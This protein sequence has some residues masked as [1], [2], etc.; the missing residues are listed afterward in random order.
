M[1]D[2]LVIVNF[3]RDADRAMPTALMNLQWRTCLR[4]ITFLHHTEL[5]LL[6][7]LPQQATVY[8]G[9]QAYQFLLEVICGLHSPLFG[10]TAVMGQFRM[11][12]A[13]AEFA[14]SA[15][16][17]FLRQLT[18]NLLVDA[19]RIRHQYLEGLGSQS[20]GSLVRKHLQSSKRIALLG[21]GSLAKEILP[22]LI[23]DAEVRL[24]YRSYSHAQRLSQEYK[25]QLDQFTMADAG[26]NGDAG[27]LVVAA[28]L[29]SDEITR[30]LELQSTRF[31]LIVDLRSNAATDPINVSQSLVR[32]SELFASLSYERKRMDQRKR[33]A[34]RD[35]ELIAGERYPATHQLCA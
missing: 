35:I 2:E 32:L 31:S 5:S 9:Q 13:S 8:R 14:S 21:T 10:E 27:A 19:R 22:W 30:W 28:P 20:Y 6:N 18:T 26:W 17:R 15:W 29:S 24:F 11:F 34:L 16:G 1:L 23:D 4:Q 7:D 25:L 12:R 3:P 33:I